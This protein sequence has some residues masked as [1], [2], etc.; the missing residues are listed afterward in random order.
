[1]H[2]HPHP[3]PRP[4]PRPHP[5]THAHTHTPTPTR[6]SPRGNMCHWRTWPLLG[7]L[8]RSGGGKRLCASVCADML[9]QPPPPPPP[10]LP[11]P[12]VL[13]TYPYD[14]GAFTQGLFIHKVN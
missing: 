4:H 1:M 3:H 6:I 7:C 11:P 9:P 5:H 10:L 8:S 14:T 12:Q 13:N 2:S